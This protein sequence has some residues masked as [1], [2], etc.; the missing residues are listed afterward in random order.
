MNNNDI[1]SRLENFLLIEIESTDRSESPLE[2][3]KHEYFE[4]MY[5]LKNK[6]QSKENL[7]QVLNPIVEY[8]ISVLRTILKSIRTF[9]ERKTGECLMKIASMDRKKHF[10]KIS[11][12]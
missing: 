5:R 10:E 6:L 4:L 1:I 3:I 7:T 2:K 8:S 12:I 11:S 9:D